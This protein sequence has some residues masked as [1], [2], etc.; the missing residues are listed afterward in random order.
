VFFNELK[1]S[2]I[3]KTKKPTPIIKPIESPKTNVGI[4]RLNCIEIEIK[5]T[6]KIIIG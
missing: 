6:K 3:L 2:V 5:I 4:L 1:I